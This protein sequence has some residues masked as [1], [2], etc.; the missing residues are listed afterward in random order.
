MF[1]CAI[2]GKECKEEDH[3]DIGKRIE[4]RKNHKLL[5]GGKACNNVD[6]SRSGKHKN[7]GDTKAVESF[8]VNGAID[9]IFYQ[10]TSDDHDADHTEQTAQK[11]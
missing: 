10:E 9:H 5:S 2:V 1:F 6:T 4:S 7:S 11:S 8:V 3:D